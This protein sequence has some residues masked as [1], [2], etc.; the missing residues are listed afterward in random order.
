[1]SFRQNTQSVN[2]KRVILIAE[3]ETVNREILGLILQKDYELLFAQDGAEALQ[4]LKEHWEM[5]SLVLLDLL[6]PRLSGLEVL[7]L[8]KA[9]MD[10]NKIPVIVVTSDQEAEVESLRLGAIDFIPKPYPKAEVILARVLRT[11]ELSEDRQII[12]TTERDALSGLYNKEYFYRYVERFDRRNREV[13]MDAIVLDVYHFH[14][15]NERYGR[16]YAD[17]VLSQIGEKLRVIVREKG[18]FACRREGDTFLLYCPHSGE[19]GDILSQMTSELSA[20]EKMQNT[21]RLRMGIYAEADKTIDAERRFDRAKLAADTVRNR[22][23]RNIAVYDQELHET[24]LFNEQLIEDFPEAIRTRQFTL[25]YQPKFDVRPEIPIPVAAEALVRWEHPRLGMVSPGVFIP[26]FEESGLIQTLDTFVW[27]EAAA[28]VRDWK[29]RLGFTIPVSVNV[30]RIDMADPELV[31]TL[32]GILRENGISPEELHLEITESAY[33]Q[34]SDQIISVVSQLREMGFQIEMDDFGTGYSSLSMISSLPIDA[35]KLD[36]Q[37]IRDAFRSGG[38]TRMLELIIDIADYL[39]VPVIAEGVETKEQYETLRSMGCDI[40]QGYY[41]SKPVRPEECERFVAERKVHRDRNIPHVV[42]PRPSQRKETIGKIAFAL[43]AG[44]ENI[45]Y[46]DSETDFY[47]KFNAAGK[48]E[49]LQIE[50]SGTDFFTDVQRSIQQHVYSEDQE[51]ISLCMRKESLLM[52][53]MGD[54]SFVVTYR[55]SVEGKAVFYSLK[56]VRGGSGDERHIVIGMSN[57]DDQVRQASVVALTGDANADFSSLAQTFAQAR[58][59]A[60]RDALTG[61]KSKHLFNETE[62]EWNTRIAEGDAEPFAVAMCDINGLKETNDE[63][64]HKAGDRLIQAAS[65][66]ICNTFKHSPVFRIGGDEFVAILKGSD[67]EQ[68]AELLKSITEK[69]KENQKNGG[70][71]VACGIAEWD[72]EKDKTFTPVFERADAKMYEIKRR[73]KEI[74]DSENSMKQ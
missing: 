6:M 57:I 60:N 1:M 43:S 22:A 30:S 10:L 37:F 16:T 55:R 74:E 49:D 40:I 61:V 35:L 44:Y 71:V 56:A 58:A 62:R 54:A 45:Y 51:R 33:T 68:R 2:G 26:L 66:V 41:F 17:Y 12:L 73:L 20:D 11:I 28:Q 47:L 64:G 53:L 15:I 67:Y 34:D 65:A 48:P 4:M 18:G 5:I 7:Q 52:Q 27:Q 42:R 3:D 24:E 46:V 69:S 9:D 38:D 25:A 13:K 19:A 31:S 39:Q 72:R 50:Y 14:M 63:K 70:V 59:L 23:A 29:D 32:S 21:V 8:M 36:M